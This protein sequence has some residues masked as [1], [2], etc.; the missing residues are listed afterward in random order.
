MKYRQLCI[1]TILLSALPAAVAADTLYHQLSTADWFERPIAEGVTWRYHHFEELFGARQS[2][3]VVEVDLSVEGTEVV[4]PIRPKGTS[5]QRTSVMTP[6]Q[7]P[8]AVAAVNATYFN[9]REPY[10]SVTYVRVGGET[11]QGDAEPT[12]FLLDGGI[13]IRDDNTVEILTK[14]PDDG[15]GILPHRDILVA[16]P[17]VVIG[18]IVE[19]NDHHGAHCTNRHPRT[20]VGITTENKLLMVTIDGRTDLA[21]GMTCNETGQLLHALGAIEAVNFDGGGSTTMWIAGEPNNGVVNYPSDNSTYD[22]AGERGAVDAIAVIAPPLAEQPPWDARLTAVEAPGH[23]LP[24]EEGTVTVTVRNIGTE[25][26]TA[27][28]VTLQVSRPQGGP[29]PFAD[30]SW[31][32]PGHPVRMTPDRVPPG[33]EGAFVYT[34]GTP[35]VEELS[36]ITD[37]LSLYRNGSRFGLPDNAIRLSIDVYTEMLDAPV[38]F[39]E[40]VPPGIHHQWFSGS[41][42]SRGGGNCT[43]EGLAGNISQ[44]YSATRRNA[45]G[46]RTGRYTPLLVEGGTYEVHVSWGEGSL[47]QPDITYTVVHAHGSEDFIVDQSATANEWIRLGDTFEFLPGLG[48]TRIEV[49]NKDTV[50]ESVSGNMYAGGVKLV[51]VE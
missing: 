28:S 3:T 34:L 17:N 14:R 22:H 37:T 16:G 42:W 21:R 5:P 51:R 44:M 19:D 24:D 38:I 43:A 29:S 11:I 45:I 13:A 31:I 36:T 12:R 46:V 7:F 26:W 9:T 27:D 50:D 23:L 39:M 18:G 32:S 49:S 33:N 10:G 25:T 30:E 47:R 15:W 2:I 8:D 4:F 48:P 35:A 41:G 40:A 20:A 1:A 6:T